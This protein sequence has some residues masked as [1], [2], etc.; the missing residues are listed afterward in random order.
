MFPGHSARRSSCASPFKDA[1]W[2]QWRIAG[3]GCYAA[4]LSQ[5]LRVQRPALAVLIRAEDFVNQ[6][7]SRFGVCFGRGGLAFVLGE[8]MQQKL[9]EAILLLLRHGTQTVDRLFHQACHANE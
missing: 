4:C 2:W 6:A 7:A 8:F 1:G 3:F 5:P 9:R